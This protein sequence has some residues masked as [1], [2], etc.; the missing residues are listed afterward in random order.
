MV[1]EELVDKKG[2]YLSYILYTNMYIYIYNIDIYSIIYNDDNY[3]YT[4]QKL[5]RE[6]GYTH[7]RVTNRS[8]QST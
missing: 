6:S 7:P 1:E 2:T 8:T 3:A 4:N 5:T